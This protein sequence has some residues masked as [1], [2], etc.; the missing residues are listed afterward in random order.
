MMACIGWNWS[1]LFKLIKYKIFVFDKV[2]ILFY[3]I[4]KMYK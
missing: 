2:Y 3:V 1:P 4:L